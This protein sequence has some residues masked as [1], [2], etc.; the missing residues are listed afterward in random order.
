[1]VV[2]CDGCGAELEAHRPE[3]HD[4]RRTWDEGRG[5]M[6]HRCPACDGQTGKKG[7]R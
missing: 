6:S 1:M 4:W 5:C 2:R 3:R 7:K